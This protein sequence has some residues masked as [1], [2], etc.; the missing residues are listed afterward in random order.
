MTR[1]INIIP[2]AASALLAGCATAEGPAPREI[3]AVL[4]AL[5]G[6]FDNAAQYAA[7]DDALK[8]P[9]APGHPYDWI[10]AQYA[11]FH[12]VDAPAVGDHVVYLEWR[13]GS[14]GG[15]ISRQRLWVFNADE[16]GRVTGMDFYTFAD[17][18]PYAGRGETAGAFEDV[19]P[20][21]LVAYPEGCTLSVA[22]PSWEGWRFEL[23][24]ETCLITA[25]SG[26]EMALFARIDVKPGAPDVVEYSESGRLE[27][28]AYAFKVHGGP[29]YR[30]AER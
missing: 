18:A 13:A 3:D 5:E 2:L 11:A 10:D 14:P 26:R 12:V 19:A 27:G 1:L 25:R 9:P 8:R 28:G 4:S 16:A 15:E 24:P 21:A 20:D 17:P 30:F 29:P 7:A 23:N 6:G 22:R